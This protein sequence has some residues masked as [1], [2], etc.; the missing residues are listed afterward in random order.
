MAEYI[1]L[2]KSALKLD[3]IHVYDLA[4]P[5]VADAKMKISYDEAAST[6]IASVAPLGS[7]YQSILRKDWKKIAGLISS[8]T[9][10]SALRLFKRMLHSMPYILMNFH[11]RQYR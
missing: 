3:E 7:D 6:V 1:A 5:L 9:R 10:K 8:K 4:C 11:E 2:R